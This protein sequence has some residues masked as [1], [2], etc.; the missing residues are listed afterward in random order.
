MGWAHMGTIMMATALV[1]ERDIASSFIATTQL[2]A[3]A[4]GSAFAGIV[5]N[6]AGFATATTPSQAINAGCWLFAA[7]CMAPVTA[8][9]TSRPM[10]RAHA[11]PAAGP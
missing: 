9:L 5:V 10:L 4:F 7:L 11:R 6:A 2:I 8:L 3:L 1:R